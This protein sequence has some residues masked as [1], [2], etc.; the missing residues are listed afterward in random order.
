M[1]SAEFATKLAGAKL[2][3]VLGHSECGAVKGAIDGAKLGKLTDLLNR[4]SPR[5][6]PTG[7]PL[8]ST[9]RRTRTSC[10][11]WRQRMLRR[12]P[13]VCN[14]TARFF[15]IWSPRRSEDRCGDARCRQRAHHVHGMRVGRPSFLG[16]YWRTHL[17][18]HCEPCLPRG[19][20]AQGLMMRA[21]QLAV[22]PRSRE[23]AP[24]PPNAA[25]PSVGFGSP[26]SIPPRQHQVR[27]SPNRDRCADISLCSFV[28]IAGH[29][30]D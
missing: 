22:S 7:T 29:H 19:S 17:A 3:V 18:G 9:P 23:R 5:L 6:R 21:G 27:L 13:K 26:T 14:E 20:P 30:Y 4:S 28:P 8:V 16:R 10:S 25:R 24:G 11:R 1:G 2:I 15:G 12:R